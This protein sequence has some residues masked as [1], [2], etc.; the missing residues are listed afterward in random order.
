MK[1]FT[2][3]ISWHNR[4]PALSLDISQPID[5]SGNLYRIAT[6]GN[7]C[8]VY[9][10]SLRTSQTPPDIGIMAGLRRHQRSVGAVKF[11]S[12]HLLASGDDD[13]YIY[14]WKYQADNEPIESS[15]FLNDDGFEDLETWQQQRV[16]RG[17]L[18]DICDLAWSKDGQ[19]LL[20]GSVDNSA[21]LWDAQKGARV[22]ASDLIKGYVQGV[23]I[24]PHT[25]YLAAISSDR[26][27]RIYNFTEKRQLYAVRQMNLKNNYK[28]FFCDDTV[29]TFCRRLEFSP[30]GQFLL[31]PT[32][33]II[34]KESKEPPKEPSELDGS[35]PQEPPK[36]V[37]PK[38]IKLQPKPMNVVLVFR[39]SSLNKPISYYPTGKEVAL[40]TRF[41]P[42][43][44][45]LKDNETNFWGLPYRLVFAI[46]TSRSVIIYD[47]Q[48]STPI[49]YVSQIHLARLTDLAWSSDG[50]LLMVSSYD[51][52]STLVTFDTDEFGELYTEPLLGL[53][54]LE[55]ACPPTI[56]PTSTPPKRGQKRSI[57]PRDSEI[58]KKEKLAEKE[59]ESMSMSI[60]KYLVTRTKADLE[61][62]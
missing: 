27:L 3:E 13:G 24:D 37:A 58:P 50:K 21:I 17:H 16:L 2:P 29:Q 33:R 26:T 60:R 56:T 41:N 49:G 4:L 30:D 55:E 28:A 62:N 36:E 47:S 54:E 61:K 40:C 31:A 34:E 46:A 7:D 22:W 9:I 11:S 53:P 38:E 48:Q 32:S 45:K 23:A 18:E 1:V 14:I 5:E 19:Y 25:Q 15:A 52:Y 44:F 12:Q 42:V 6:G 59:K 43:A 39:R 51:G 20:S 57:T 8:R 10:W 35:P